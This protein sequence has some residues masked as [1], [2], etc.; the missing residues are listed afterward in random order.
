M[1]DGFCAF[2]QNGDGFVEKKDEFDKVN[3]ATYLLLTQDSTLIKHLP[4]F[5]LAPPTT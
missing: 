1:V 5:S 2:Q 4:M 3:N